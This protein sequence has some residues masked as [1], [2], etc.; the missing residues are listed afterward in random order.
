MNPMASSGRRISDFFERIERRLGNTFERWLGNRTPS[1]WTVLIPVIV[2]TS[3]FVGWRVI[4]L[5]DSIV[6]TAPVGWYLLISAG[7]Y[8]MFGRHLKA[9]IWISSAFASGVLLAICHMVGAL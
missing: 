9:M 3:A 8:M 5:P 4:G 6:L 7:A 1:K 2:V